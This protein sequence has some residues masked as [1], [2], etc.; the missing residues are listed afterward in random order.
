MVMQNVLLFGISS[1]LIF[2]CSLFYI[3]YYKQ[4]IFISKNQQIL[5][6]INPANTA[7]VFDIHKVFMYQNF[8]TITLQVV[9]SRYSIPLLL[10]S[11]RP[12]FWITFH[13]ITSQS[14][15]AEYVL[16]ELETIY[17][18]LAGF[19]NFFEQLLLEQKP[20]YKTVAYIQELKKE[21]YA[22][23]ILSNCAQETFDKMAK[24]YPEIFNLFDTAYVP[25]KQ[26]NYRSKPNPVFFKEGVLAL[27]KS[28]H[29]MHKQFIFIDDKK[30]NILAG[31]KEQ[32]VGIHFLSIKQLLA[33][34]NTLK[35]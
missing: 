19:P 28:P 4:T 8:S 11:L 16:R 26:N 7:F 1:I 29:L 2:C 3:S 24:I 18:Q 23:G 15:V 6:P 17:P 21:G 12:S 33:D 27:K 10:V 20:M 34:I 35:K 31:L 9:F 13:K 14:R 32:L 25:S 5:T 22:L 30:R